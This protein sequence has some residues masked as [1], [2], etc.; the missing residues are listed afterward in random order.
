MVLTTYLHL[1]FEVENDYTAPLPPPNLQYAFMMSTGTDR[2]FVFHRLLSSVSVLTF[3]VVFSSSY[4]LTRP[5]FLLLLARPRILILFDSSRCLPSCFDQFLFR[6]S[7]GC[8]F[9][10]FRQNGEKRLLASSCLSFCLSVRPSVRPSV[11]QHGTTQRPL[12]GLS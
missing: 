10:S 2:L 3:L 11:F 9:L 8:L 6:S 4:R 5:R 7:V 12:D 1:P